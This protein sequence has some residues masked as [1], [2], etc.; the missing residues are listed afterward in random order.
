MI[1][2]CNK[3]AFLI[4]ILVEIANF[5]EMFSDAVNLRLPWIKEIL[6]LWKTPAKMIKIVYKKLLTLAFSGYII[7]IVLE[8]NICTRAKNKNSQNN[9][10]LY[11]R[12][13]FLAVTGLLLCLSG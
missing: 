8:Q 4:G 10:T 11:G 7:G 6:S 12:P 3:S 5:Y 13:V 1:V 9:S 2:A